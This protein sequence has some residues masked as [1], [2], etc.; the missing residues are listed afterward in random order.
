MELL[1]IPV[2]ITIGKKF[3]ETGNLEIKIR[4]TGEVFAKTIVE[5][6]DFVEN[7]SKKL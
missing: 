6:K 4:K 7:I 1:G 5:L 3:I 2:S